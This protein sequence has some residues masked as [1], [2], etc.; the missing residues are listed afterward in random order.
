MLNYE[1]LLG[2]LFNDNNANVLIKPTQSHFFRRI[3]SNNLLNDA[4]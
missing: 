2:C 4:A 1:I 3:Y